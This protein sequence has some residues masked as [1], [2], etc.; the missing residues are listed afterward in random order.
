M[1]V[2]SLRALVPALALVA[3]GV[4]LRAALLLLS[5]LLDEAAQL[6]GEDERERRERPAKSARESVSGAFRRGV[7]A[8]AGDALLERRGKRLLGQRA[9]AVISEARSSVG[10]GV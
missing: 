2:A 9:L 7:G 4:L 5:L 6:V 3:L 1:T 8:S 10:D